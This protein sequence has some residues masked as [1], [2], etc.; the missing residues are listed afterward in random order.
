MHRF[1]LGALFQCAHTV[2]GGHS[3][4][5]IY[6]DLVAIKLKGLK[7]ISNTASVQL[8]EN[9][10]QEATLLIFIVLLHREEDPA[11]EE[12]LRAPIHRPLRPRPRPRPRPH[13]PPPPRGR[14]YLR[15]EFTSPY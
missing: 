4:P 1:K 7:Q 15:G 12:S 14:S 11:C 8:S 10:I 3:I 2:L 13:R 6:Y 5:C 9:I